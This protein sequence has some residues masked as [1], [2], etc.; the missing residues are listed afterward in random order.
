MKKGLITLRFNRCFKRPFIVKKGANNYVEWNGDP[1]DANVNLE[2][3]YT[4]EKVSFS[5]LAS[6]LIVDADAAR[7]LARLRDNVV[8]AAKL[9]GKLF[10]PKIDF[11][12]EFPNNSQIFNIPS[13][14]FAIQQLE[15]NTNEL[16]KQVTFL[17]VTNSFAPYESTQAI[18][19]PLKS[20][21]T[22]L[23]QAFYITLSTSN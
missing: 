16:T 8:V 4:A 19:R 18:E 14:A 22:T 2:A 10:T 9:T 21:R 6:T 23:F 7:S 13:V 1:Y 17:V 15:R 5:P 20:W 11:T 3:S 12:L